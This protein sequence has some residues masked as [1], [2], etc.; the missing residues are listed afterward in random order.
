MDEKAE[1]ANRFSAFLESQPNTVLKALI[2]ELGPENRER[3]GNAL[4]HF[5]RPVIETAKQIDLSPLWD[6]RW[7]RHNII[8]AAEEALED[9]TVPT[10]RAES[11]REK[12]ALFIES[13]DRFADDKALSPATR[14]AALM[15]IGAALLIGA[16]SPDGEAVREAGAKFKRDQAAMARQALAAKTALHK[17]ETLAAVRAAM[18]KVSAR[19]TTG[20]AY[21]RHIQPLVR[22]RLGRAVSVSTVRR[23]VKAILEERA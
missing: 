5:L 6:G 12:R 1:A 19:S 15:A 7:T 14:A 3:F 9:P 10:E 21:A 17:S 20:E 16:E 11:I 22:E 13:F 2:V 4:E 18:E 8:Q 23:Y